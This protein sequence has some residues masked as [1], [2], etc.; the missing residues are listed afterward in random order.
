MLPLPHPIAT[1][2]AYKIG[3][4]GNGALDLFPGTS[5]QRLMP[6]AEVN[7]R[8]RLFGS[9][10]PGAMSSMDPLNDDRDWA[11]KN[12]VSRGERQVAD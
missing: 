1:R 8:A 4:Q 5:A 2:P 12:R 7:R 6:A 11:R 3:M 10:S 9:F